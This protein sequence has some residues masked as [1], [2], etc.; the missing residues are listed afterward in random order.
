MLCVPGSEQSQ[1]LQCHNVLNI[2]T[3][4]YR[5][6]QMKIFFVFRIDIKKP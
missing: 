6:M 3:D 2:A 1:L 5:V 4:F